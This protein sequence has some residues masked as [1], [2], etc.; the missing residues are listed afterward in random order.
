MPA[1]QALDQLLLAPIDKESFREYL[2]PDAKRASSFAYG[3]NAR[4][5][6]L[7]AYYERV[8]ELCERLRVNPNV[9]AWLSKLDELE[10]AIPVHDHANL[11]EFRHVNI[12][13]RLL[14]DQD[15][16]SVS[17][18]SDLWVDDILNALALDSVIQ[19]RLVAVY[20]CPDE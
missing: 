11:S 2:Y 18:W 9:R 1:A 10:L 6:Q 16:E 12:P 4:A 19:V 15:S 8:L 7:V 14:R 13:Q 5:E 20:S 3:W 17:L